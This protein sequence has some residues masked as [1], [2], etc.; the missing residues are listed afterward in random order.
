M[1]PCHHSTVD[2][3]R[4][5]YT[6]Y[7]KEKRKQTIKEK[8]KTKKMNRKRERKKIYTRCILKKTRRKSLSFPL[9]R[10]RG[11]QHLKRNYLEKKE[12]MTKKKS[13]LVNRVIGQRTWLVVAEVR[14]KGRNSFS[15][16]RLTCI[17]SLRLSLFARTSARYFIFNLI[18]LVHPIRSSSIW[19]LLFHLRFFYTCAVP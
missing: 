4:T 18:T 2:K 7:E 16:M 9:P 8:T 17:V 12:K 11:D 6:V 13:L 14:Q 10:R 3:K 15:M 19:H 5:T 1:P